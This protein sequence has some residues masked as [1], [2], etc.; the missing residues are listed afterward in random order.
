MTIFLSF[1]AG[2]TAAVILY[3][4]VALMVRQIIALMKGDED[5]FERL[6]TPYDDAVLVTMRDFGISKK[7]F[8]KMWKELQSKDSDALPYDVYLKLRDQK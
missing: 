5:Q 3:G 4:M 6:T 2:I 8:E 1:V 7:E